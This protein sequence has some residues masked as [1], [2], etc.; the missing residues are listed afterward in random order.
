MFFFQSIDWDN[1]LTVKVS[2]EIHSKTP[3]ALSP[4]FDSL[5][6]DNGAMTQTGA[7][8]RGARGPHNK[9]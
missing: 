3:A 7:R 9:L 6:S 2:G 4:Y 1:F 8:F 5:G